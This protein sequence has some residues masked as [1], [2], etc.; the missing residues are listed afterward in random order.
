MPK[1]GLDRSLLIVILIIITIAVA[2]VLS[3]ITAAPGS[4][5][6]TGTLAGNVT[7]GPLCPVEPCTVTPDRLTA[8]Y[9]ARTIVVSMPGGV[10]V[11]QAVPDPYTGFSFV[12][13]PGTYIVDI[14]HQGID[15]SPELPKTVTIHAGETIRLDISIDT[16]IR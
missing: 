16:G 13:K 12:L 5:G 7:I 1:P 3:T 15:R 10:V 9:A 6:G 11:A 2:I 8:A 4:G 14:K